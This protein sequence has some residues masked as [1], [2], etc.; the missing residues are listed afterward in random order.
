M[1]DFV[2][3]SPERSL[4]PAGVLL[5]EAQLLVNHERQLM[6]INKPIKALA[7]QVTALSEQVKNLT[8]PDIEQGMRYEDLP[9]Y[10]T[11][12]ELKQYLRCG[13]T[14]VYE[15][16]NTKGFPSLR[17]GSKFIFPKDRVKAWVDREVEMRMQY[18]KLKNIKGGI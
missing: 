15:L 16:A 11:I 13:E 14:R 6:E 9:D 1:D 8:R 12:K 10:L 5:K 3:D 17:H 2:S 7:Q 4:T 18:K